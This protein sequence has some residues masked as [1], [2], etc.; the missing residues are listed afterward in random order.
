MNIKLMA[1]MGCVGLVSMDTMAEHTVSLVASPGIAH[2]VVIV[3]HSAAITPQTQQTL[4][5]DARNTSFTVIAK[6]IKPPTKYQPNPQGNI[7]M[8][9]TNLLN[10]GLGLFGKSCNYTTYVFAN[11]NNCTSAL[12]SS[13]FPCS[14]CFGTSSKGF[15]GPYFG[16][17]AT[18]WSYT[19]CVSGQSKR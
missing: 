17:C 6:S 3:N 11:Y 1:V 10:Q 5:F 2:A 15:G 19:G 13:N 4:S 9:L 7:T 18:N 16:V 12:G 14:G 8:P